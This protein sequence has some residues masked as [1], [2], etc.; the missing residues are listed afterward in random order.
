[1]R[2]V[3]KSCNIDENRKVDLS[4]DM[5]IRLAVLTFIWPVAYQKAQTQTEAK[6]FNRK[7]AACRK[8]SVYD[9]LLS[10]SPKYIELDGLQQHTI[11]ALSNNNPIKALNVLIPRTPVKILL[12][13][14]IPCQ[15]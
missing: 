12:V 14:Q 10:Y 1:M 7:S 5:Y 6:Y 13:S 11:D 15:N 3:R 2:F 9:D 8:S 4:I